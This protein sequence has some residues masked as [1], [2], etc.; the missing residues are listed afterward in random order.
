[1]KS[2]A[3]RRINE[4]RSDKTFV[5]DRTT[6]LVT[7]STKSRASTESRRTLSLQQRRRQKR[8]NGRLPSTEASETSHADSRLEAAADSTV[9]GL[10]PRATTYRTYG[11]H[12]AIPA[13]T[14]V[15]DFHGG[16]Q[17]QDV[18]DVRPVQLHPKDSLTSPKLE[19]ELIQASDDSSTSSQHQQ[20]QD[21]ARFVS[22]GKK[23][24][25][26]KA[27]I[28]S[29][30]TGTCETSTLKDD[31]VH[32]T[33]IELGKSYENMAILEHDR[34]PSAFD[35]TTADSSINKDESRPGMWST[36]RH[37]RADMPKIMFHTTTEEN[38]KKP[39]QQT[40]PAAGTTKQVVR[41]WKFQQSRSLV[42][43]QNEGSEG[44]RHQIVSSESIIRPIDSSPSDTV[45][46]GAESDID[47]EQSLPVYRLPRPVIG[48][49]NVLKAA[50]AVP[51]SRVENRRPPRATVKWSGLDDLQHQNRSRLSTPV[52]KGLNDVSATTSSDETDYVCNPAATPEK[53]T[54]RR[55][56]TP[57]P[58][59]RR[60][61]SCDSG[62]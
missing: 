18:K 40:P 1:M 49:L 7:Q 33:D 39:S 16:R 41:P 8:A 37:K 51:V 5:V 32:T 20:L 12:V 28:I 15:V 38:D 6:D 62:E 31:L 2:E 14:N 61:V 50:T 4:T 52:D 59:S 13:P 54:R 17:Q 24:K 58:S 43:R 27:G 45:V 22:R 19:M 48:S 3:A 57:P 23:R 21:V 53:R 36:K 35:D 10:S 42:S 55:Q 11:P 9:T 34:L 56:S 60:Q 46:L 30:N 29:E 47:R 25:K 44:I 26:W